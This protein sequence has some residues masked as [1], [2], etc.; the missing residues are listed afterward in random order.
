VG[1]AIRAP[2]GQTAREARAA[3]LY[4]VGSGGRA[5]SSRPSTFT[6]TCRLCTRPA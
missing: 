5:A 2:E 3:T 1:D 4:S 6:L